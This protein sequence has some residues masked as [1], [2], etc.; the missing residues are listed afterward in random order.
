VVLVAV[1][2]IVVTQGEGLEHD[3]KNHE[4]GYHV[5]QRLDDQCYNELEILEHAQLL[6]EAKPRKDGQHYVFFKGIFFIFKVFVSNKL[7]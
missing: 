6:Q 4:K 3:N 7:N 1:Y 5:I 2:H